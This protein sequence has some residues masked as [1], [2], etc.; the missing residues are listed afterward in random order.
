MSQMVGK[1]G[2][3]VW[4]DCEMTGLDHEKQ[5][6]VEIAVILT[7]KDLNILDFLANET[8]KQACPLAGNSVHLDRRFIAKYMPRLDK[9]LHY[10]IVDVSTIKELA[11]R[12][13]PKEFKKAPLKRQ[14]HRA[15][16][17]IRESIEELRY[18]RSSIFHQ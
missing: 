8:V 2:R 4:I 12:W 17:D 18:Y 9:H 5:T 7:D 14:T 16:D 3:L 1:M 11:A 6:L 10:R 15:L 13:Y